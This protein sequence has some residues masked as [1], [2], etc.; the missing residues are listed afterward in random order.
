MNRKQL[1]GVAIVLLVVSALMYL[2]GAVVWATIR[3]TV[4]ITLDTAQNAVTYLAFDY[5]LL[6]LSMVLLGMAS[7][8]P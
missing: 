5:F 7:K 6:T 8:R 4:G 2:L 3:A 1:T